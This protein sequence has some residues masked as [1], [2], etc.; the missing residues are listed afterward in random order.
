MNATLADAMPYLEFLLL[1][2]VASLVVLF[3]M[4]LREIRSVSRWRAVLRCPVRLR[5][6]RVEFRIVGDGTPAEVLHCSIFGR[7][8][9]TCGKVCASHLG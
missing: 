1:V 3:L 5:R 7:S 8:P 9:I 2:T 4:S 6:A